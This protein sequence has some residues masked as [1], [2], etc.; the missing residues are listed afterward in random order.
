MKQ[1]RVFR[2]RRNRR[3]I[4]DEREP[5]WSVCYFTKLV[6]WGTGMCCFIFLYDTIELTMRCI[7]IDTRN[8]HEGC[9]RDGDIRDCM[10]WHA[11]MLG[12]DE[13]IVRR[14]RVLLHWASMKTWI[15]TTY[16]EWLGLFQDGTDNDKTSME[17]TT[18]PW[19]VCLATAT[20][21]DVDNPL[22][23]L[24][25][26][27]L[28]TVTY[29][30]AKSCD[31]LYRAKTDGFVNRVSRVEMAKDGDP[32]TWSCILYIEWSRWFGWRNIWR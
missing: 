26:Q 15:L 2:R 6:V 23:C 18:R 10:R 21:T 3:R 12:R 16:Y 19:W 17:T 30:E 29:L 22:C 32:T 8:G 13:E 1:L 20:T 4:W 14:E 9:A 5:N 27:T 7:K 31:E 28:F 25:G 11:T 24:Y